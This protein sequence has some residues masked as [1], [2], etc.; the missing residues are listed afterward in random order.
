MR[1]FRNTANQL[2]NSYVFCCSFY[3]TLIMAKTAV[4]NGSL[5]Q[6][7]Q[8]MPFT[9]LVFN[10]DNFLPHQLE[11]TLHCIAVEWVRIQ[12]AFEHN[13]NVIVAQYVHVCIT[14][15]KRIVNNN[16]AVFVCIGC[17]SVRSAFWRQSGAYYLTGAPTSIYFP[18]LVTF[19]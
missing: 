4:G 7:I 12:I 3:F 14:I 1:L 16:N 11:T 5:I 9:C 15:T 13:I 17:K 19:T 18:T 10:R 6:L 2:S 8:L